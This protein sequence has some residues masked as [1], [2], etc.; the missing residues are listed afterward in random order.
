MILYHFTDLYNLH[1]PEDGRTILKEGLKPNGIK[2]CCKDGMPPLNA[3]WL[4]SQ[5]DPHYM[6]GCDD[7]T[8][9]PEW[10]TNRV[11]IRVAIPSTDKRLLKW[12]TWLRRQTFVIMS[13]GRLLLPSEIIDC[14]SASNLTDYK[15]H[16]VYL[17]VVPLS[18]F[19]AVEY[20]DPQKRTD[21]QILAQIERELRACETET[22]C[23]L[24]NEEETEL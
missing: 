4:T 17:G 13:D 18:K 6:F 14:F 7:D 21:P 3:V 8:P 11:R 20:A 24:P 5:S 22:S 9:D 23:N 10:K 1:H 15:F 2:R 12:E 19:R 16:Y